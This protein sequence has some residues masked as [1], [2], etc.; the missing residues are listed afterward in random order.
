MIPTTCAD[1][2]FF[3]IRSAVVTKLR[4]TPL[5]CWEVE[6]PVFRFLR[7]R[8]GITCVLVAY[9]TVREQLGTGA[10]VASDATETVMDARPPM[11]IET[12]CFHLI[13]VRCLKRIFVKAHRRKAEEW[14]R[15]ACGD[16]AMRRER[17]QQQWQR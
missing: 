17:Q 11:L 5:A 6:R 10:V 9:A 12:L 14:L 8:N 2:F 7:Q 13:I 3:L 1:F 4:H 16:L 15:D